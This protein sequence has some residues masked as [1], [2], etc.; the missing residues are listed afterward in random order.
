MRAI[1][2]LLALTFVVFYLASNS[3]GP[4]PSNATATKPLAKMTAA[5]LPPPRVWTEDPKPK[6]KLTIEKQSWH[7]GGFGSVAIFK[8]TV[9]NANDYLV[10]DIRF[11]CSFYGKSGT[12][13]TETTKT[14]YDV[15]KPKAKKTFSDISIGFVDSQSARGGCSIEDAA[16]G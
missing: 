2:I 10:K 9:S 11:R 15:V 16:R 6:D 3:S 1:A 4:A 8:F 13:L 14:I 5:E 12:T 7:L